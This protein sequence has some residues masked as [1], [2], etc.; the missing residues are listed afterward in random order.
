MAGKCS[1]LSEAPH[2]AVTDVRMGGGSKCLTN[3]NDP[4][5]GSSNCKSFANIRIPRSGAAQLSVARKVSS[6]INNL[7]LWSAD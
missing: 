6:I 1:R 7:H 5:F 3:F 2:E 4:N